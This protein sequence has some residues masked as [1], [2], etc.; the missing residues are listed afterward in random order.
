MNYNELQM[1]ILSQ[2]LNYK[3]NCKSPYFF[4]V[5]QHEYKKNQIN[6]WLFMSMIFILIQIKFII[7]INNDELLKTISKH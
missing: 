2:K 7:D 4:I 6:K 3:A 1:I 5:H